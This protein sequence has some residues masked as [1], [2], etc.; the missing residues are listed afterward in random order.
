MNSTNHKCKQLAVHYLTFKTLRC[1][2]RNT[3]HRASQQRT[4]LRLRKAR[5]NG[6]YQL[7]DWQETPVTVFIGFERASVMILPI[8]IP[9]HQ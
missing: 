7:D 1:M 3:Q 9:F 4:M 6:S 5:V 2:A 8:T